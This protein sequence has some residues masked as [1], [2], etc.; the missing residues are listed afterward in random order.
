MQPRNCA[1]VIFCQLCWE[2]AVKYL[3]LLAVACI[4]SLAACEY[5]EQTTV[6]PA[7]AATAVVTPVPTGAAVVTTPTTSTTTVY[8][9]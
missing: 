2:I 5:R 7:P 9:R 4:A 8:T 6:K 1:A 3:P